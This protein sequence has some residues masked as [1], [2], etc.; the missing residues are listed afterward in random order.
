MSKPVLSLVDPVSLPPALQRP[1]LAVGNF[2]GVHLG[3]KELIIRAA[4]LG[5]QRGVPAA[6]LTFEPHPR[7]F[8]QPDKTL[9]R[10]T[11]PVLKARWAT[12]LGLAGMITLTFGHALAALTAEAFVTDILMGRLH[13][14]GVVIGHDFHFGKGRQGTP[15]FLKAMGLAHGFDVL[16]VPPVTLDGEAVSSSAIRRLLSEGDIHGANRLLGREWT[17]C[18]QVA[19][20]DKRGRLLGYPT[21]NLILGQDVTLKHGIYAVRASVDGLIRNG[22][23]SFGRRPTF[24]DGAPRLEV[25]LFDFA[26]D[27]Y[28]KIMDVTFAGYLRPELKFD[29]VEPLIRQMDADSRRARDMLAGAP[30]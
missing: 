26:G 30:G 22:V 6:L 25:H 2:D 16:T 14:S 7:A 19:H 24:D 4:T 17:V 3:H 29:G 28:G 12:E 9:F 10:L 20:G 18:A 11:D 23:A 1:V 21:A 15:D 13:T 5:Q 8:F 27:L